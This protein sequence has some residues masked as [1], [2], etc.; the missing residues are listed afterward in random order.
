MKQTEETKKIMKERFGHDT[1]LSVAT[2]D[3]NRPDV[4]M[5]NAYYENGAFYII[6]YA[7]SGKMQQIAKN[8]I[9]AVCGEWFTAH[10]IAA[11]LGYVLD[12]SNSEIMVKLRAVFA[13]WYDNG[14]TDESDPNT[15]IL[16]IKLTDGL[17][18]NKGTRYEIDFT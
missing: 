6:T 2:I 13:N 3:G 15:C 17:L 4:R 12:S 16:Q 10:G 11:N 9:V 8:S 1:V 5:V 18:F 14:H 7:L